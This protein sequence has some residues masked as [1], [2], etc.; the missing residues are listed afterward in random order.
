MSDSDSRPAVAPARRH[1]LK[2]WPTFFAAVKR[3]DKRF[4]VRRN[5][6][7]F[8]VGDVLLLHEWD[9]SLPSAHVL[10]SDGAYTGA[11]LRCSV[12]Y[13]MP[14]GNFGL[15]PDFCVLGISQP[16]DYDDGPF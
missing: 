14:G 7:D 13:V 6:R 5:D 8:G 12:T 2:T 3:G 1:D 16:E 11:V 10:R 4:E 9:P 15:A